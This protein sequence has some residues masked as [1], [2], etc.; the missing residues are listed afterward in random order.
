MTSRI[1]GQHTNDTSHQLPLS[2]QESESKLRMS[3]LDF[4]LKVMPMEDKTLDP[5]RFTVES[6]KEGAENPYRRRPSFNEFVPCNSY[7][8]SSFFAAPI[9]YL[10]PKKLQHL[11]SV[12]VF[13]LAPYKNTFSLPLVIVSFLSI[14]DL[15]DSRVKTSITDMRHMRKNIFKESFKKDIF[16]PFFE[17]RTVLYPKDIY[18]NLLNFGSDQVKHNFC[19]GNMA[20]SLFHKISMSIKYFSLG[21]QL[22]FYQKYFVQF[23]EDLT[24]LPLIPK[25]LGDPDQRNVTTISSYMDKLDK[26]NLSQTKYFCIERLAKKD[27]ESINEKDCHILP[28]QYLKIFEEKTYG[29]KAII[30]SCDRGEKPKVFFFEDAQTYIY[31]SFQEGFQASNQHTWN[32]VLT[33]LNKTIERYKN[34]DETNMQTDPFLIQEI[35]RNGGL[36]IY[37]QES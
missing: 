36:F 5:N 25:L 27:L 35:M 1:N 33:L 16:D 21:E 3:L 30:Y 23:N 8:P 29:L 11:T 34:L 18:V 24:F 7:Q 32:S 12:R 6:S 28:D 17:K 13:G 2:P 15:L 14:T 9:Q 22:S 10:K 20:R 4:W 37:E 19:T 26:T 31:E